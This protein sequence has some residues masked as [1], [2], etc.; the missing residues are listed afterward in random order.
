[1]LNVTI[2]GI[3]AQVPEGSTI[4]QAAEIAGVKIPTLC[5]LKDVTPEASCRMCMVEI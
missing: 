1:L 4:F 3:K 2:D 5:Y